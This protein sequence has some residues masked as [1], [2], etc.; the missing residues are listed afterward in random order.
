MFHVFFEVDNRCVNLHLVLP[1]VL[2][3]LLLE[4]KLSAISGHQSIDEIDLDLVIIDYMWNI[5]AWAIE[6]EVAINCTVVGRA[7]FQA[8]F[9]DLRLSTL[10]GERDWFLD[11]FKVA[12]GEEFNVDVLD[13][14]VAAVDH[15]DLQLDVVVVHFCDG[16][17]VDWVRI[18]SQ[19]VD[20]L[21]NVRLDFFHEGALSVVGAT[22]LF[23]DVELVDGLALALQLPVD[24]GLVRLR[25]HHAFMLQTL[26]FAQR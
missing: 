8:A 15:H 9:N 18:A 13:R 11:D 5:A 26:L 1:V 19:L 16:L 21:V 20:L 14:F 2:R 23:G 3:P 6:T 12:L 25:D 24:N 4:F 10:Q 17:G 22:D 7:D